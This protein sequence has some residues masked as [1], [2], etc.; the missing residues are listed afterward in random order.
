MNFV[1]QFFG[2]GI[3]MHQKYKSMLYKIEK[4]NW[5]LSRSSP[6][7]NARKLLRRFWLQKRPPIQRA[8][9]WSL[10][11]ESETPYRSK[12]PQRVNFKSARAFERGNRTSGGFPLRCNVYLIPLSAF[13]FGKTGAKKKAWQKRNR[14]GDHFAL[15]GE[16]QG[17]CALDRTAF[18][19]KAGENFSSVRWW[20]TTR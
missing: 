16:R 17:L 4:I 9:R 2:V 11:A 18:L 15:C 12:A 10:S 6:P 8:Q 13:F 5:S 3:S 20:R 19:E 1:L 14:R 7:P